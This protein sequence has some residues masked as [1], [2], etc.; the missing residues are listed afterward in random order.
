MPENIIKID[1]NLVS[2]VFQTAMETLEDSHLYGSNLWP[3]NGFMS[4]WQ[5]PKKADTIGLVIDANHFKEWYGL[6]FNIWG[7]NLT[8]TQKQHNQL[9]LIFDQSFRNGLLFEFDFELAAYR[10][11]WN[12]N[13]DFIFSRISLKYTIQKLKF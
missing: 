3:K 7:K 6:Q 11:M 8:R 4:G 9:S 13:E 2:L 12:Y 5:K 1:R 10:F